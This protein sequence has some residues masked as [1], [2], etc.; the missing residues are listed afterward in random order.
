LVAVALLSARVPD[1]VLKLTLLDVG[2]GDAMVLHW[3]DGRVWLVDGGPP[4]RQVASYLR[5]AGLTHLDA[6]VVSHGHEDHIGGLPEVLNRIQVDTLLYRDAEGLEELLALAQAK[7]ILA[8]RAD[9]AL[10]FPRVPQDADINDRSAVVLACAGPVGVLLPGD[11]EHASEAAMMPRL[12][13]VSVLKVGH[14]GSRTSSSE[15]FLQTIDPAVAVASMGRGNRFGHPHAEVVDRYRELGIPLF[16]TD[17]DGTIEVTVHP[18]KVSVQSWL[19][20]Q[21]WRHRGDF[22]PVPVGPEVLPSACLVGGVGRTTQRG[23]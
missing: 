12:G 7:G 20:G 4:S 13:Q 1:G 3:P 23:E 17:R 6:V 15:A 19:P 18:H 8:K 14:H 9:P 16:R 22:A 11:A 5:R 10:W 21:G 2:Q